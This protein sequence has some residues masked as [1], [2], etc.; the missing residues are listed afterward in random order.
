[1]TLLIKARQNRLVAIALKTELATRKTDQA[2]VLF[3]SRRVADNLN[4]APL[5][6]KKTA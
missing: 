5:L 1:M 4:H 6:L 2:Q 3:R